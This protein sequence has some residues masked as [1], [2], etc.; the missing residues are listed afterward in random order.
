MWGHGGATYGSWSYVMGDQ[1]GKHL[2]AISL[3]GD[4]S[5]LSTFDSVLDA[6]F[7]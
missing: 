6:A 7:C 2:V 1:A 4:Y 3:H 5:G